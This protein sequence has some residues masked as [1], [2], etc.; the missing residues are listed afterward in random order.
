MGSN[1]A[2]PLKIAVLGAG[3]WGTALAC[4]LAGPHRVW[5]WGHDPKQMR[6]LCETRTNPRYLPGVSFPESLVCTDRLDEALE[7][8]ALCLIVT[9]FGA[10]E[11]T[12]QAVAAQ[13]PPPALLWACK[14][15]EVTTGRL[16][17]DI[18]GAVLG[19]DAPFG[20]LTGPSFADEL[21]RGQPTAALI[22]AHSPAFAQHWADVLHQPR[23]RLYASADLVGAQLGGAVKNVIAIAAGIS[24]GLGFGLNARAALITRGLAEMARLGECLGAQRDTLMG[25]SGMGDL[26]L[27]CTGDL[28]RNRRFG[29]A[30]ATGQRTAAILSTLGHVAEGVGTAQAVCHLAR[31]FGI[32]MPIAQAVLG[33]I[34]DRLT[35]AQAV[36]ALLQREPGQE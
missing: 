31:R 32:E 9:P 34:E 3:A 36:S 24:D 8:A 12:T 26:I 14:G 15:I 7:A 18:V 28:S 1:P 35:P 4:T 5:L 21:A 2:F 10:L 6:V 30:L 27:T 25:L 33:L 17:H 22:A 29:M 19:E 20:V 11:A 13:G 16:G 23:F